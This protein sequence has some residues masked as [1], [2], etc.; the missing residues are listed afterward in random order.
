MPTLFP[1]NTLSAAW[2]HFKQHVVAYTCDAGVINLRYE[3]TEQGDIINVVI[4]YLEINDV[5]ALHQMLKL[6]VDDLP[7]EPV[8]IGRG[9]EM[10]TIIFKGYAAQ[11]REFGLDRFCYK[12]KVFVTRG[13]DCVLVDAPTEDE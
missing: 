5:P 2:N 6:I 11:Y 7:I 12:D 10:G 8:G 1:V 3:D 9:S 13:L 4:N